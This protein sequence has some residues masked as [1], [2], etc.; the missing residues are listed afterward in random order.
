LRGR[1]LE[2]VGNTEEGLQSKLKA[3]ERDPF[4]ALVHVQVALSYWN[5]RR[6]EKTAEWA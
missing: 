6:Y 5:Q 3:L 4:S 2:S 1:L